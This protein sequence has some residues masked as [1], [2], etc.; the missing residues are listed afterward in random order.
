MT[1]Q[2]LT[3]LE[4]KVSY[5]EDLLQALNNIIAQQQQQIT[6][7]ERTCQII[8]ERIN[9]LHME[10]NDDSVEPPPPHY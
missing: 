6:R 8:N 1:E 4:I 2:R 5:Q 7:L 10:K 9:S 3:E